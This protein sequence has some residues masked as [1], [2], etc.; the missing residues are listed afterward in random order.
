MKIILMAMVLFSATTFLH[1]ESLG[2]VDLQRVF[3][4]YKETE[5][6]RTDFEK[7]QK[8]LRSELEEKQKT[9]EKAQKDNKKP[10]EIQALVEEIQDELQPKQEALIKLNNQL[11]ATIRADILASAKK[12]A[13]NYGIDMVLDK[14]AVLTGGFDL[15]DFVIEDLNN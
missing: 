4:N 6:A 2:V 15:T 14:Q 11:M 7:K 13:K 3:M 9:L 8:E 5:V 1:A 12:V 10:A